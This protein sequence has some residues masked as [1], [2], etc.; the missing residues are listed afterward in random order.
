MLDV[1]QQRAR[2]ALAASDD[3]LCAQLL[4]ACTAD[5]GLLLPM[6]FQE[7]VAAGLPQTAV[8]IARAEAA[9]QELREAEATYARGSY[10]HAAAAA[11]AHPEVLEALIAAGAGGLE[12]RDDDGCTP[13][14]LAAT[15]AHETL[16][17][18]HAL[19]AAGADPLAR[20]KAGRT[21]RG[22]GGLSEEVRRLQGAWKCKKLSV[23]GGRQAGARA[24][25]SASA[26]QNTPLLPHLPEGQGAAGRG[27]GG[28][29][30][31]KIQEARGA[32]GHTGQEDP[33]RVSLPHGLPVMPGTAC[34]QLVHFPA[35]TVDAPH[36]SVETLRSLLSLP[37]QHRPAHNHQAE[38]GHA[39]H[40]S[41]YGG[42]RCCC[43]RSSCRSCLLLL[44]LLLPIVLPAF[45]LP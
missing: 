43:R 7:V 28:C 11:G 20:N 13:L 41:L 19:L 6:T 15:A 21:A 1:M 39:H 44:L 30:G 4:K 25:L 16:Q 10:L 9:G 23:G 26:A 27:G 18:V 14:F 17:A 29:Q 37:G 40:T 35:W 34:G 31:R 12:D 8:V 42:P 45:Q 5:G 24:V 3:A 22:Q 32:V 33:D 38:K 36:F 2:A